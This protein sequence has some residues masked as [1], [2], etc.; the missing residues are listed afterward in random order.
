M[1]GWVDK[2]LFI[3]FFLKEIF[4]EFVIG[5]EVVEVWLVVMVIVFFVLVVVENEVDVD[6]IKFDCEVWK[7]L[8]LVF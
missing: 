2:F 7:I 5:G 3:D 1:F 8:I 4:I 6:F